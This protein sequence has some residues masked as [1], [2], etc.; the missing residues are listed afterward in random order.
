MAVLF[1]DYKTDGNWR[2]RWETL[3]PPEPIVVEWSD[4]LEKQISVG[5]LRWREQPVTLIVV[6]DEGTVKGKLKAASDKA[7]EKNVSPPFRLKV[8]TTRLGGK[9]TDNQWGCLSA[10]PVPSNQNLS[11]LTSR[12][13][14]LVRKLDELWEPNPAGVDLEELRKAWSIWN[15]EDTV[16][17]VGQ[18]A[19]STD[20]QSTHSPAK[21]TLQL[22]DQKLRDILVG[23]SIVMQAW[24]F[25]QRGDKQRLPR[26]LADQIG[27]P[28]WWRSK[29]GLATDDESANSNAK[30]LAEKILQKKVALEKTVYEDDQTIHARQQAKA[31]CGEIIPLIDAALTGTGSIDPKKVAVALAALER[32]FQ[33]II[34]A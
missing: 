10:R 6:H 27:T 28:V 22:T 33:M 20:D 3:F 19:S 25:H 23:F 4:E 15:D 21:P 26:H 29:L 18:S 12:F 16:S 24:L 5:E 11:R 7:R 9:I 32:D 14:R 2:K 13:R 34:D 30:A 1:I 8:S 17:I 31:T